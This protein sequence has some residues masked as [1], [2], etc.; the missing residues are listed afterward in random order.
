MRTL[1][2]A[3]AATTSLALVATVS[4]QAF[5][6][7]FDG[8]MSDSFTAAH[9]KSMD[10]AFAIS[11][12]IGKGLLQ[13][14]SLAP[15]KAGQQGYWKAVDRVNRLEAYLPGAGGRANVSVLLVDSQMW[16]RFKATESGYEL[17]P[18]TAGP[19]D[20]D[21]VVLTGEPVIAA[22]IDGRLPLKTAFE[23]GVLAVDG[24]ANSARHF[25]SAMSLRSDAQAP[26]R[27]PMPFM[28]RKPAQPR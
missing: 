17:T 25:A 18:H 1:L 26:G 20:G 8:A 3:I 11:D 16:S 24:E 2:H 15:P 27:Q 23:T 7:G 22:M 12:A 10:V 4:P 19:A 5:A 9:P 21:I 28:A 14:A 13:A 6:C